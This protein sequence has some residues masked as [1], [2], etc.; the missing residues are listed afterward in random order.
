MSTPPSSSSPSP[1]DDFRTGYLLHFNYQHSPG[2]PPIPGVSWYVPAGE[3]LWSVLQSKDAAIAAIA[4][5]QVKAHLGAEIR[6]YNVDAWNPWCSYN[7]TDIA[8]IMAA[9]ET[10]DDNMKALVAACVNKRG[11]L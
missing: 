6:M 2:I 8:L 1:A 10:S 11:D 4:R 3:L 7:I 9:G 5:E